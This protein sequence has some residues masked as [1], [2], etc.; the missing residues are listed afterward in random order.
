M[1]LGTI[2]ARLAS[3]K[4]ANVASEEMPFADLRALFKA[5]KFS[6]GKIKIGGKVQ[7]VAELRLY[8][9]PDKRIKFDGGG[10]PVTLAGDMDS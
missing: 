10:R 5:A 6:G 8:S 2:Q 1:R 7:Q 9:R 3:G 4:W